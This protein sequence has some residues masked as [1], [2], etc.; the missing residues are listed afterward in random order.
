[1]KQL[2]LHK[3]IDSFFKNEISSLNNFNVV[4]EFEIDTNFDAKQYFFFVASTYDKD[5]FD[6]IESQKLFDG[7]KQSQSEISYRTPELDYLL[8]MTEKYADGVS[9]IICANSDIKNPYVLGQFI[10]ITDKL[11]S[12]NIEEIVEKIFDNNWIEALNDYTKTGYEFEQIIKKLSEDKKNDA[13]LKIAK[14][15]LSTKKIKNNELAEAGLYF[16]D[17]FYVKN[18]THSGLFT[19]LS[20]IEDK[21]ELIKII[22]QIL[23]NIVENSGS[24]PDTESI[25]KYRDSFSLYD[26]NLFEMEIDENPSYLHDADEKNL[27]ALF[28]NSIRDIVEKSDKEQVNKLWNVLNDIPETRLI[29]RIKLV[30]LSYAKKTLTLELEEAF[31]RL[32]D[33][34]VKTYYDIE[35]GPEYKNALQLAFDVIEKKKEYIDCVFEFFKKQI[36][37]HP[38]QLWHKRNVWEILSSISNFLIQDGVDYKELCKKEFEENPDSSFEPKPSVGRV[39]IGNVVRESPVNISEYSVQDIFKNLKDSWTPEK[40]KEEREEDNFF[41]RKDAEGLADEIKNNFKQKVSD[42]LNILSSDT[43][44]T[45][46]HPQ[47]IYSIL[48]AI[49]DISRENKNWSNEEIILILNSFLNIKKQMTKKLF[50]KKEDENSWLAN[51]VTVHKPIA[52]ILISILSKASSKDII[53]EYKKDILEIIQYLLTISE[54]PSPEQEL[55]STNDLYGIAINSVMGRSFEVF[56]LYTEKLGD[57]LSSE[58]KDAYKKIIENKS[59]AVQFVVGRYLAS[60]YF[61]DKNFIKSLFKDIFPCDGSSKHSAAWEGYLSNSLYK[62]IFIDLKEYYEYAIENIEDPEPNRKRVN[63]LNKALGIHFAL[64]FLYLGYKHDSDDI[65]SVFWKSDN[66]E[67][68]NEF[69]DFIGRTIINRDSS[70][71]ESLKEQ[72]IDTKKI[73]NFWDWVLEQKKDIGKEI[74]SGFGFWINPNKEVLEDTDI[75]PRIAKTLKISGGDIDWEYGLTKRL[76]IFAIIDAKNTI[77]IIKN[78]LLDKEGKLNQN[79]RAPLFVVDNEIKDALDI[80]YKK[81]ELKSEI[82]ELID[83]LLIQGN[84]TFWGLKEIVKDDIS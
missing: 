47:Y 42:Y 58:I 78:F 19:A 67:A 80:I 69:I 12:K 23:K 60:F 79:R 8:S 68:M 62:E 10:W 24:E 43:E 84:R 66:Y 6:W 64:A 46:I 56:V 3:K 25:F 55:E 72:N 45:L 28:I 59:L 5:W 11:P 15:I 14:Q 53:I 82:I 77:D 17:Q 71:K 70:S 44:I 39:Q 2:K 83:S 34:S 48:R 4:E 50:A 27:L 32:F 63:G 7:I 37:A 21:V 73:L 20:R 31:F 40:I 52:D 81:G 1:M 13:L 51:W 36:E 57:T 65:V 16:G 35:G 22:S 9:R 75:I 61:R 30:F 18:I 33:S 41:V 49:E 38:N 26:E 29:W 74:F 54:S 76:P